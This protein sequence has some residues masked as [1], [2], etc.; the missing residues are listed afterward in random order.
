MGS[1]GIVVMVSEVPGC[2]APCLYKLSVDQLITWSM[3]L[4]CF[5]V[6]I[7]F[8]PWAKSSGLVIQLGVK[9]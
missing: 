6:K 2:V 3:Y 7:L 5:N 1:C 4:T 9:F 8:Q